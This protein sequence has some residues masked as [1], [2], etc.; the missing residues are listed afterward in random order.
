MTASV[1][2]SESDIF[3][4][5]RSFLLGVLP[6][7]IEIFKGQ[8][9]RVPE[10]V[11]ADFIVMTPIF[12]ARIET[13][14]DGYNDVAFIGSIAGPTLTVTAVL[15]GEIAVGQIISGAG[16]AAG[17]RITAL[18]SGTGG[19]G[20]YTIAPPQTVSSTTIQAGE[21][22][23]TQPTNCTVQLDVHGPAG[24]DNAQII[25]TLFRDD[26]AAEQFAALGFGVVPLYA[27]DPK[28]MPFV[29]GEGQYEDRWVVDVM[30]QVNPIV[31]VPQQFAST[32]AVG[33][34]EIDATYPPGG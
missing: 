13:N 34:I 5:L 25:S 4:A 14:I 18:G 31:G 20:T 8:G 33:I 19:I 15:I 28:Q 23:A 22:Q 12:R 24:A 3:T 32:A 6:A 16:I 7:G 1:S 17:T 27:E 30:M 9:N 26:F 21:L 10:P 11:A 29:N 2:I